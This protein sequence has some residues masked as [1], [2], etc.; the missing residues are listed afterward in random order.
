M[1]ICKDQKDHVV[2]HRLIGVGRVR[3]LILSSVT[4]SAGVGSANTKQARNFHTR[5]YTHLA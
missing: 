5:S 1:Y 2:A 4:A 3:D